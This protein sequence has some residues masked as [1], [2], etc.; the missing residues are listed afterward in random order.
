MPQYDAAVIGSGPG[1]YVAALRLAQLGKRTVLIEK[2]KLGG[3]CTNY[4][5]IPSKTLLH[6]AKILDY[7]EKA[8]RYGVKL[9]VEAIDVEGLRKWRD[10]VVNSLSGGIKFLCDNYGVD[11]VQGE[12]RLRSG[13]EIEVRSDMVKSI[14]ASSIVLATGSKP[15]QLRGLEYD[16]ETIIGS[17]EAMEMR[18]IPRRLLIIGGG[19]VGVEAATLYSRLGSEVTIV[20]MMP[21]ILPGAD[22]EVARFMEKSLTQR[23]VKVLTNS[24]VES[25]DRKGGEAIVTAASRNGRVTVEADKVLVAVGRRPASEGLEVIGVNMDERGH[26]KVDKSM[27]TNA[28]GIYAV[29]DLVGP[30]YLAHKAMRQGKVAAE[31]IAGASSEFD[32]TYVPSVIYS[33]PEVVFVGLTEDEAKARGQV[34]IGRFPLSASGRARTM[35][36][37]N[38]FVKVIADASDGRLLGIHMVGYGASELAAEAVMMLEFMATLDDV[39][40]VIH[41]HPT[42]SEALLEAVEAARKRSVHIYQR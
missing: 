19:V 38:G 40:M 3:E 14:S 28:P 6:V 41:P 36:E 7:A 39:E 18:G 26:V 4:A 35:D 42:L 29:G 10:S 9:R 2:D 37:A 31:V 24:R 15:I 12:A 25:V 23:G 16:G 1:G 27:R 20:E 30:P 22:L 33:D 17:R 21:Q 13:R 34:L 32:S 5:C 11:V 8:A